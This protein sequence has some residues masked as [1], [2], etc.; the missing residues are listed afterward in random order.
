MGTF[1]GLEMARKALF[2]QQSAIYTTGHNIANANTEGYSRQRVNFQTTTP[3]PM[4]SRVQPQIA[5][6][7]GTG[8]KVGAVQRIRDQFL[9]AQYR[10][11]NSKLGYW[12]TKSTSFSRMENL[13]NEPS[14][15][16][17]S[18]V[19]DEFWQSL[20]ELSVH[21][22]N[23]G[24]RKVVA[25]RGL[26]V[27]ETFNYL[28]KNLKSIQGDLKSQI[29]AMAGADNESSDINSILRQINAINMQVQK[30]EPH[31]YVA[32]D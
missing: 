17:L 29:N 25:E 9:D 10:A 24:A 28:S 14:E 19:M 2:A 13:L 27:A 26:A 3:F 32:N 15:H 11:E 23:T 12:Q 8:V 16:G 20:N 4:P 6:Q 1:Y 30:L 7:M 31:G 5:G 18:H 21:P 22:D